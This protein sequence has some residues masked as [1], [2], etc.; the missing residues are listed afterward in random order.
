[1]DQ[2]IDN[3]NA[4]TSNNEVAL[5][6]LVRKLDATLAQMKNVEAQLDRVEKLVDQNYEQVQGCVRLWKQTREY[7]GQ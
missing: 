3:S 6:E 7:G 1:M 5:Q 4:H 2:N